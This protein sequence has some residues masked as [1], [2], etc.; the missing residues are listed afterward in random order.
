MRQYKEVTARERYQ[1]AQSFHLQV[2]HIR[3][4][5]CLSKNAAIFGHGGYCPS[6]D[7]EFIVPSEAPL[8]VGLLLVL[9]GGVSLMAFLTR[10]VWHLW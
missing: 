5:Q 9:L 7:L 1:L 8:L 10:L 2:G 4:P 3:C 6:C